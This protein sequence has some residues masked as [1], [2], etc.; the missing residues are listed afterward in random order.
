MS[1]LLTGWGRYT[2]WEKSKVDR[3]FLYEV[4]GET[5]LTTQEGSKIPQLLK[6]GGKG[7]KG[8]VFFHSCIPR[9]FSFTLFFC[10]WGTTLF[11]LGSEWA[12][13]WIWAPALRICVISGKLFS[14]CFN[15]VS[16]VTWWELYYFLPVCEVNG[17]KCWTVL[18]TFALAGATERGE[19]PW[20]GKGHWWT[21]GWSCM[22]GQE[23]E[24]GAI[25]VATRAGPGWASLF[26]SLRLFPADWEWS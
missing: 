26:L 4:E 9:H 23:A 16:S 3:S 17:I 7:N 8:L 22:S 25:L 6:H 21:C 11:I 1:H 10:P 19:E 14:L 2:R 20:R 18:L 5:G 12:W 13:V 24:A 15:V